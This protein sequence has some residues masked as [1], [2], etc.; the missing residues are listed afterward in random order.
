[1]D[2]TDV[3]L[4]AAVRALSDVVAPVVG[5][6]HAQ[7]RDQLRLTIDYLAFVAERLPHLHQ[8]DRFEL[9]HHLAMAQAVRPVLQDGA[10][11]SALGMAV[12]TGR[13]ALALPDATTAEVR[14]ATAEL[15][16]ALSAVVRESAAMTPAVQREVERT[17]LRVSRERI[18]FERA[19]YLPLGLDPDPHDVQPLTAWLPAS[20]H[21]AC[22]ATPET[23]P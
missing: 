9:S 7:A 15:G 21:R 8:R 13:K 23:S 3:G 18:A 20:R 17:V 12:D 4:R 5:A 2:H 10:G 22:P 1:M 11:A 19:W 14:Q 16:A 6:E